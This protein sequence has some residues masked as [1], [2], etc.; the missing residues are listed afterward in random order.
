MAGCFAGL[1]LHAASGHIARTDLR[2]LNVSQR[3]PDF[4]EPWVITQERV[5]NPQQI[6]A[7]IVLLA[8]LLF[9]RRAWI[10]GL[11]TMSAFGVFALT[12]LTKHIVHELPPYKLQHAEYVGLF[13]SN[14]SFPSGHVVGFS[15]LGGLLFLFADR[16]TRDK[17]LVFLLRLFAFVCVASIG[18]GRVWLSVHYPTDVIAAYLLAGLFLLPV[19]FCFSLWRRTMRRQD[20]T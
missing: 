20:G 16:L 19:W 1:A 2:L 3:L 10:E 15:V 8:L 18:P 4:I 5:G 12:V 7:C 14:Y 9:A 11:V 13:E 17:V 6:G